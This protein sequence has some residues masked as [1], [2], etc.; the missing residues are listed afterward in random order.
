MA[1]DSSLLY[2]S[3]QEAIQTRDEFL[4]IA[5]HELRTPLTSLL[6]RLDAIERSA[7]EGRPVDARY[8]E[9]SLDVIQRQAKRLS[10]L[11]EQLLDVSQMRRG[12]LDLHREEA[13]LA[14]ILR[15][16]SG[17]LAGSLALAG[18]SLSLCAPA[19]VVG[20][21]DRLR[22]EQVITNLLSNAIKFAQSTAIEA[23]VEAD[24]TVAR[25]FV[26]DRGMGI[27][28]LDHERIFERFERAASPKHFGG[29][30]L[31]LY[32]TRQIVEAHGGTIRV[33][34][35]PGE[36]STFLVELPLRP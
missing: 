12:R 13:D 16:V 7:K 28:P 22:M 9:S 6:L 24:A 14:E 27:A 34:S 31:G 18:C 15:E 35:A 8:V 33:S 10:T 19:P 32:I 1:I 30:G 4:S 36:G 26:R 25:L 17:R 2:R 3:A 21:W 20:H 5:S 23:G 11:V 29:L